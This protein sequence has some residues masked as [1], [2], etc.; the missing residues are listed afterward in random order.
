MIDDIAERVGPMMTTSSTTRALLLVSAGVS[1]S[2]G[3]SCGKPSGGKGMADAGRAD[4]GAVATA[5]APARGPAAPGEILADLEESKLTLA[6]IKDRDLI[7]PVVG[8]V[9]LRDGRVTLGGASPSARLSVDLN[10]YDSRIPL[11]N[12]RVKKFFFETTG[13][14]WET[15]ELVIPRLPDAVVASLR[16]TRK[17]THAKLDGELKVHGHTSKLVLVVDAAYE[18][19]GRLTV[20]TAA[21]VEVKVSDLGMTDNLKRLSAICMHDSIDD[22]VKVE[23]TLEFG[24]R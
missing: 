20:K 23:A 2:C 24:G 7:L 21:P 15:A 18:S 12:E 3:L 10:T 8:T 16:D 4:A 9:M 14:G 11:R 1:V 6:A 13:L 19:D 17:A 5:V 22:V